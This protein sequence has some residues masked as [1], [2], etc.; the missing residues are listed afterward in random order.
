MDVPTLV[1]GSPATFSGTTNANAAVV[2]N[3]AF[4]TQSGISGSQGNFCAQSQLSPPTGNGQVF[5]TSADGAGNYS[6]TVPVP[7]AATGLTVNFQ[8]YGS[9]TCPDPCDSTVVT[10]TVL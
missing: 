10:R 3:Y 5:S 4:A 6:R 1:G 2:V 7:G 8:A 9:G